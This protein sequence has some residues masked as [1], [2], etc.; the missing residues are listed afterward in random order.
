VIGSWAKSN[1]GIRETI[2]PVIAV[3]AA[4][5]LVLL[6]PAMLLLI[7]LNV[8]AVVGAATICALFP[9]LNCAVDTDAASSGVRTGP[10]LQF[11]QPVRATVPAAESGSA[12]MPSDLPL[13]AMLRVGFPYALTGVIVAEFL[14]QGGLFAMMMREVNYLD[15]G[16]VSAIIILVAAFTAA[17]WSVLSAMENGTRA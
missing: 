14:G 8:M 7:G 3:F 15:T 9:M 12:W 5:P 16:L 10:V 4:I 2:Q 17:V 6:I 13:F 11:N 1:D